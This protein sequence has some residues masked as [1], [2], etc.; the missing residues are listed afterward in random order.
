VQSKKS[1]FGQWLVQTLHAVGCG[2]F[3]QNQLTDRVS[4]VP[5]VF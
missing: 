2:L 1:F 3:F 4:D 5:L